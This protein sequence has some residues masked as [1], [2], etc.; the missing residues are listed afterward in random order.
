MATRPITPYDTQQ[1][2]ARYFGV[3]PR[4]IRNWI[5]KGLI[6]GYRLPNQRGVRVRIAEIE[7]MLELVPTTVMR[8][9][10]TSYGPKARI[11]VVSD[12][13]VPPGAALGRLRD[14]SDG[15][16]S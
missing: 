16:G 4:T 3:D 15:A 10:R 6:T 14:G 5:S 2:A 12:T 8:T 9:P 1:D 11:V 7:Q 13:L